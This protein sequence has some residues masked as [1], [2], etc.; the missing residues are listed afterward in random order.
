MRCLCVRYFSGWLG[1]G[2]GGWAAVRGGWDKNTKYWTLV[3]AG[4][5]LGRR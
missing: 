2:H 1:E 3:V 4:G 5:G